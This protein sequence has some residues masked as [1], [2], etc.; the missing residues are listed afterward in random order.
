MKNK[1][2]SFDPASY[3]N[4]GWATAEISY[5]KDELKQV[6]CEAGTF[7]TQGDDPWRVLWPMFVFI[8]DFLTLNKPDLA[9]IED[10]KGFTGGFI[11][12]QVSQCMGVIL[13]ACVKHEIEVEFVYPSHVKKV[14]TGD[15]RA[16]KSQIKN[17][18]KSRL[19][20]MGTEKDETKFNSG[21]AYDAVS[22]ILC[23][24]IENPKIPYKGDIQ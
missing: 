13:A 9:I 1:V 2:V 10:T 11:T 23:W 6:A 3:R 16:T 24:M 19:L 18:V 4:L 22:N 5:K 14:V 7:V 21:H 20:A 8:D 17:G 12:G 15:G